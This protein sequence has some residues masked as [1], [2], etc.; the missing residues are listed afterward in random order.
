MRLKLRLKLLTAAVLGSALATAVV[1]PAATAA[2][3]LAL[4][5]LALMAVASDVGKLTKE[6][7]AEAYAA[8]YLAGRRREAAPADAKRGN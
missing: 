1:F 3:S 8:G 4:A 6:K 7:V 5:A 2:F